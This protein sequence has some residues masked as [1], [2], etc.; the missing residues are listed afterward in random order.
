[1][2]FRCPRSSCSAQMTAVEYRGG[3]WFRPEQAV[4]QCALCGK[5]LIAIHSPETAPARLLQPVT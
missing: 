4:Y 3:T 5:R 1:M 2:D